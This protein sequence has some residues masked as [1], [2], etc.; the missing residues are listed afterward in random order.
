MRIVLGVELLR[1][2]IDVG[3]IHPLERCLGFGL[4]RG[5]RHVG[6]HLDFFFDLRLDR[7][8]LGL[9]RNALVDESLREGG[10]GVTFGFFFT[11]AGWLVEDFVVRE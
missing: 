1:R 6:G 10:H 8:D 9:G 4:R 7:F 2:R 3:R 11:L 5:E